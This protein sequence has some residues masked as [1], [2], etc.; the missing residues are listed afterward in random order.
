VISPSRWTNSAMLR[1]VIGAH[2]NLLRGGVW[3]GR[4]GG[5]ECVCALAHQVPLPAWMAGTRQPIP[6]D[7]HIQILQL[8]RYHPSDGYLVKLFLSETI[9]NPYTTFDDETQASSF[10]LQ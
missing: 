6:G 2:T 8:A 1:S 4:P 9:Q 5:T 10:G 3:T 7:G